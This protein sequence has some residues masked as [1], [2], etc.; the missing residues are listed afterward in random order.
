[1]EVIKVNKPLS[2]KNGYHP[3]WFCKK[4]DR[5]TK[6]ETKCQN[7]GSKEIREMVFFEDK[8]IKSALEYF[9]QYS[10]SARSIFRKKFPSKYEEY[11][12]LG[13][14]EGWDIEEDES[15]NCWLLEQSFPD[16]I[17]PQRDNKPLSEV[18]ADSSH[19]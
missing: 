1:M 4:C 3:V 2:K 7:C 17:N 10:D 19:N 12:T 6:D 15:W 18:S 5:F 14:K 8:A 16:L 9:M 13:K 11:I